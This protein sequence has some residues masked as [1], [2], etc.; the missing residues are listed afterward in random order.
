MA[1]TI[2]EPPDTKACR[3][4]LE[5]ARECCSPALLAHS[6]RSY[7]WASVYARDRG[8]DVDSELLYVSALLHDVG[9]TEAFDNH[10]LP[11]EIAGAHVVRAFTA[12]AG[13][14]V[15]RREHAAGVVVKHMWESVDPNEDAEGFLLEMSTG[16]DISGRGRE[17]FPDELCAKVLARY[18]RLNLATEFTSAFQDQAIRKPHC[19]AAMAVHSGI[20]DRLARNPLEHLG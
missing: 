2:L 16:F 4:A 17:N 14:P 13:W 3:N 11:F 15:E 6:I 5:V 19:T 12:G 10:S 1:V 20:A 18:P 8:M 7:I 9:L